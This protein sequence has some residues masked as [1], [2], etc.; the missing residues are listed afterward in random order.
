[1]NGHLESDSIEKV[2]DKISREGNE[3]MGI[4]G[5]SVNV[6]YTGRIQGKTGSS[7]RKIPVCS[8]PVR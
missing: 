2:D 5:F 4:R 7:G 1:M 6:L 8:E 3:L